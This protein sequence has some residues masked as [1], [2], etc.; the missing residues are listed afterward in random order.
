MRFTWLILTSILIGIL[1]WLADSSLTA[2]P[3]VAEPP[4]APREFRAAWVATVENIDWPS[5]PGLSTAEQ[6]A[7]IDSILEAANSLNLNAIVLQVRTTADAMYASE[8]EPWSVYLT[9]KQGVPPSPYYDPLEYW[10]SAAHARGIELHAWFNPYRAQMRPGELAESHVSHTM[11]ESV[12]KYDRYLWLDPGSAQAAKHSLAVFNDVVR[13]YDIDGI[14]IDDYFY[15]YPVTKDEIKLPFRD[16]A[17]FAEYQTGGGELARDDWRRQNINKLIEQI[18]HTTHAIKPHVRFGISPFGIGR[19]G[20]AIG[21]TGFDQYQELYADAGL[22][23]KQGWCDYFTPQLYW[24]IAQQPQSFPVLLDYWRSEN[25]HHRY[26]WPGLFTSRVG[27]KTRPYAAQE[28][29]DQIEVVRSR[30]E[31]PGHVHFSMKALLKNREGL[32]DTL[33]QGIYG[34][35]ALTPAMIWLDDTPPL[36]PKI[37][38][39][40]AADGSLT[41]D[42]TPANDEPVWLW[43]VWSQTADT[44]TFTTVPGHTSSFALPPSTTA[45]RVTAVDRC[46]NESARVANN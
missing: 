40:Q 41:L 25:A 7:E 34:S 20:T 32:A 16:D 31:A 27:S 5:Q 4:T 28:I 1:P 42:L 22:W 46:G 9:G 3:P 33:Q 11:P 19:P 8:L 21:I 18:Y 23:L 35:P 14:H 15:P 44:W 6:Q 37:N 39:V 45:W 38:V 36:P 43:A 13:R 24:P 30:D 26:V 2:E 17:S 12:K 29:V 10:T